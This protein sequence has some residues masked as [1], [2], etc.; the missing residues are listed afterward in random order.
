MERIE[1]AQLAL[2]IRHRYGTKVRVESVSEEQQELTFVLYDS[3]VVKCAID[4]RYGSVGI[5]IQLDEHS[6]VRS[7]LGQRMTMN[8]DEEAVR[9]SLDLVDTYCRLRL[10]DKFLDAYDAFDTA[11]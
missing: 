7:F 6:V 5:G 8:D 3:F 2:L 10:P 11:L 9:R 1:I 4:L